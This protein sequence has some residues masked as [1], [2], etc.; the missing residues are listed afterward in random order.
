[1]A[2]LSRHLI[3]RALGLGAVLFLALAAAASS[4]AAAAV[5]APRPSR[6]ITVDL[7]THRFRPSRRAGGGGRERRSFLYQVEP[8]GGAWRP[9]TTP[10][11]TPLPRARQVAGRTDLQPL[12]GGRRLAHAHPS[13]HE[14]RLTLTDS[15]GRV[16]RA[17]RITSATEL[18]ALQATP[19]M[20]GNDLVVTTEVT[21]TAAG[22]RRH[23]FLVLR[24][25]PDGH[26]ARLALD[27]L[28]VAWGDTITA[29]RVG[30]G[31]AVYQ[32]DS[33]PATGARR[34]RLPASPERTA[35][36]GATAPSGPSTNP[37]RTATPTP[38]ETAPPPTTSRP[39]EATSG[40]TT[41]GSAL[42]WT[43]GSAIAAAGLAGGG[44]LTYRRFHA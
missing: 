43:L 23:E 9:L 41:D 44:W 1:M 33:S 16:V 35:E 34:Y 6:W 18:G 30:P 21:G 39:P 8:S 37:G 15:G 36:L 13:K 28:N 40:D 24:L 5:S 7:G 10:T 22:A 2:R 14:L 12:P 19:V 38:A 17:W 11:G 29:L 20:V 25:S 3:R 31:A 32:L 26:V 27:A 4:G 42:W